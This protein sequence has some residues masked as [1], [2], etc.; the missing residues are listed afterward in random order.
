[1]GWKDLLSADEPV[2]HVLPWAGG[3]QVHSDTRSWTLKGRSPPEHGWY[4][5]LEEGARKVRLQDLEMLSA[6]PDFT[7]K[8]LK[9][10]VIG[11]RFIADGSH[12]DPDPMKL[13]TQT[14]EVFCVER[15]LERFTRATVFRDREGRLIYLQQLWPEGA[16]QEALEAYQ[17][18]KESLDGIKGVTPALDLAF[19]WIT[20]GRAMAEERAREEERLR[21]E[22]LARLEKEERI[23]QVMKDADHG[24]GIRALAKIDFEAAARRALAFSDSELLDVRD[25]YSKHEK[26]IQYRFRYRRL[27]CI[28]HAETLRVIDAGVC[29]DNHRGTK[30]DTFFTL[31]S[32][33]GVI[34]EAMD[35]HHLVVWRHVP[36]DQD[37][38]NDRDQDDDDW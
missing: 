15:G 14:E 22:E 32:L 33:P 4:A 11:D 23:R 9:G 38:Q 37:Y 35:H 1:V 36:G 21:Q 31:E 2:T 5:F 3:R 28:V 10:Y 26:V 19:Q 34:G 27:E 25:G 20:W 6:E 12:V 13:I 24:P 16:E 7:T 30:G 8:V 29:L 17:D 18:R